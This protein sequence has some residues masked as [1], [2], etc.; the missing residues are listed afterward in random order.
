VIAEVVAHSPWRD[1]PIESVEL[2]VGSNEAS[3]AAAI[4][5]AFRA[6]ERG[7]TDQALA[8]GVRE[9]VAY[10]FVLE[11]LARKGSGTA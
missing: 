4:G 2:G 3:G 8:V 6:V 9:G 11:R 7:D 5:A 10:A 1:V